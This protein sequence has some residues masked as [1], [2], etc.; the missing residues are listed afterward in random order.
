[1]VEGRELRL[2]NLEKPMYPTGFTKAQVIDYYRRVAP[3]MLPHLK[4][5]PI[6][7]VRWPHGTGDKSFFEKRVPQGAPEW[8]QVVDV[9][10]KGESIPFVL[11][12]DVPTLVWLANLAALELH[13]QLHLAKEPERPT[14]VV[15]DLDPGPPAA[16][17]EACRV[18]LR[19]RDVLDALGLECWAKVSGGKGIQVY[20]PLN[21]PGVTYE[22]TKAFSQGIA[23]VL[24]RETPGE[25]VSRQAKE[26][27]KGKVLVDWS[28]NDQVKTTVGVYS[29]RGRPK[30]T[31]AAP[32]TWEE[33]ERAV[34][35][36]DADTLVF[37]PDDVLARVEEHG[38][39]FEPVAK[40]KQKLPKL[41]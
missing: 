27:R 21:T 22:D 41:A 39:L 29:L 4:G 20:L 25:V 34:A 8:V 26:L 13:P 7:R 35:A 38:D 3:A 36:E 23:R 16:L 33:I 15:F 37:E 40:K 32:V 18:A 19:V 24:E 12:E 17:L 10:H 5:R 11:V 6:T 31:V 28:Q 14:L 2:T 1:M 30:P 9:T